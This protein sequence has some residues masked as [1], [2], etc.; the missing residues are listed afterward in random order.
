[1]LPRNSIAETNVI[2]DLLSV[3]QFTWNSPFPVLS[4][5]SSRLS[6]Q[7]T[8][9]ILLL[10]SKSLQKEKFEKGKNAFLSL[11]IMVKMPS[12]KGL[13][14]SSWYHQNPARDKTEHLSS[15]IPR[16]FRQVPNPF[17]SLH[18]IPWSKIIMKSPWNPPM[19]LQL[20]P[21]FTL[22]ITLIRRKI[23]TSLTWLKPTGFCSMVLIVQVPSNN[24]DSS[25]EYELN[26][27][28]ISKRLC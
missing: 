14:G 9:E 13:S 7:E 27:H 23:D 11:H 16:D 6:W 8:D 5:F 4:L 2:W 19:F 12:D 3:K 28:F 26:T 15:D 24:Q 20:N 21:T 22:L 18:L 25:Y 17:E 10:R 1:M